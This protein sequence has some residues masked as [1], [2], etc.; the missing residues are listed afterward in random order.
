[1]WANDTVVLVSHRYDLVRF[2]N[3]GATGS[4]YTVSPDRKQAI[5]HLLFYSNRGPDAASVRV[6]G[7]YRYARISPPTSLAARSVEMVSQKEAVEVHLPQVSQ[8]VA[9]ELE[10]KD[11]SRRQYKCSAV[12]LAGNGF[13]PRRAPSPAR[14]W[15]VRRSPVPRRRPQRRWPS[16]DARPITQRTA[17]GARDHVRPTRRIGHS[18]QGQDRRHENQSHRRAHLSDRLSSARRHALHQPVCDRCRRS[19]HG[20]GRRASHS[21]SGEPLVHRRSGGR[22]RHAG[23]LGAA[24]HP[25]RRRRTWSSKTPTTWDTQRNI[26]AWWSRTAVTSSR[27]ST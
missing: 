23:Q 14:G 10:A 7:R 13:P 16:H 1:M 24:R 15:R 4:F 18:G 8:Y 12:I 25:G 11:G 3:G 19:P 27:H 26:P 6:V 2:W 20:Q 22:I 21:H 17:A 5:V 9:L